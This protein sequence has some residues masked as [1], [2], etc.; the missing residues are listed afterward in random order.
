MAFTTHLNHVSASNFARRIAADNGRELCLL[1]PLMNALAAYHAGFN[2]GFNCAEAVNFGLKEWIPVGGAAALTTVLYDMQR[3]AC[4][5]LGQYAGLCFT[6]ICLLAVTS[7]I[8]TPCAFS[9]DRQH[10]ATYASS[11]VQY[12]VRRSARRRCRAAAAL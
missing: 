5:G 11:P 10:A 6:P 8:C 7:C 4:A 9:A 3:Y 1:L 12:P 2:S